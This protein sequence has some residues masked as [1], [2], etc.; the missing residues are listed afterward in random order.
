MSMMKVFTVHYEDQDGVTQQ[1][2]ILAPD[3]KEARALIAL[4]PSA[5]KVTKVEEAI[6]VDQ[7]QPS[8]V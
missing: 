5:V 1:D 3:K 2:Q 4:R 8:V 7:I 6:P